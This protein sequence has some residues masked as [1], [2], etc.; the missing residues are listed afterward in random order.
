MEGNL[1]SSA[2]FGERHFKM[3]YRKLI[4]FG[5]SSFI[6]SLPKSWIRQ[7]KLKKG[8]LIYFE[9][10]GSNLFLQPRTS[11]TGEEEKEITISVDGKDLRRIYRELIS[12]YI[13]NYKTITF[14]GNEIKKNAKEIQNLTHNLV[15]LE[16]LEQDSKK[17]VTKDFLNLNNISTTQILRKMDVITRSMIS[18]CKNMFE[19]DNCESIAQRDIDV[20][21]FR[22]LIYRIAWF[23]IDNPSLIYRKLKL[24]Q[25]DLISS[26][27]LAM[28]IEAIADHAKKIAEHMKT[29]D[30]PEK[31]KNELVRLLG[32]LEALYLE[33]MKAYYTQNVEMAH[34]ILHE[35]FKLIQECDHFYQK[36]KGAHTGIGYLVY[37]M[38][39]FIATTYKICRIV[40]EGMPG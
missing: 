10:S 3:E 4:S 22:F 14:A 28:T 27:W 6:V 17:I 16:I 18:D 30:L 13:Q 26:W 19:E 9:E 39:F 31:K 12:A 20:N 11:E 8:D 15:A 33:T 40:Y 23:G 25:K 38:K 32:D 1:L 34:N 5:K 7:N 21:K 36:N 37:D 2:S 29:I 24:E 35:R